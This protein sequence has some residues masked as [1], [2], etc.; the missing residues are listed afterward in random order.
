MYQQLQCP[1]NDEETDS[2]IATVSISVTGDEGAL[3]DID[4]FSETTDGVYIYWE[5]AR[6]QDL[7][8]L[9]TATMDIPFGLVLPSDYAYG[10]TTKYP[11]VLYLHGA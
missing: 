4:D 11:L 2:S 8:I 7:N 6:Y 3:I 9:G 10:N 1:L 5:K